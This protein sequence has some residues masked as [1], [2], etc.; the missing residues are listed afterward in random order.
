VALSQGELSQTTSDVKRRCSTLFVGTLR[1]GK[2]FNRRNKSPCFNEQ[3]KQRTLRIFGEQVLDAL[4]RLFKILPTPFGLK[5]R[6][7]KR[8]RR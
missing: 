5:A 6:L 7:E 8:I 3:E 2:L 4:V 1:L